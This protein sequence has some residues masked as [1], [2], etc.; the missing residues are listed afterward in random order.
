[1]KQEYKNREEKTTQRALHYRPNS[2]TTVVGLSSRTY[3]YSTVLCVQQGFG[4]QNA[5]SYAPP[6]LEG[7]R[8]D[9]QLAECRLQHQVTM[10][11]TPRE[12]ALR[13]SQGVVVRGLR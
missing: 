5:R 6:S 11:G 9:F 10:R 4:A 7:S 13:A 3:F 8:F 1:V 2:V 12:A